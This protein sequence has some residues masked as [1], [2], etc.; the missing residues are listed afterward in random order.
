M[1]EAG[2]PVATRVGTVTLRHLKSIKR[3]HSVVSGAVDNT[4]TLW[5]IGFPSHFMG[6]LSLSPLQLRTRGGHWVFEGPF[7]A[8]PI[9]SLLVVA[10]S[11]GGVCL[12]TQHC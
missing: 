3:Q 12:V 2:S 11:D 9:L 8:H 7:K 10:S 5:P 4:E 6:G 1:G